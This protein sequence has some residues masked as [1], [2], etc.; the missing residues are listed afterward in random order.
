LFRRLSPAAIVPSGQSPTTR[1]AIAAAEIDFSNAEF[2]TL[3]SGL[4]KTH[5]STT[6][7]RLGATV[8]GT[9]PCSTG[10]HPKLQQKEKGDS[11]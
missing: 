3:A 1:P 11:K 2:C 10:G 9:D 7:G 4:M 5:F 6:M 8:A